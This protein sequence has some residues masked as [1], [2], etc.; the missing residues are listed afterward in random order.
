MCIG[1]SP[2]NN[3]VRMAGYSAVIQS[4]KVLLKEGES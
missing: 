1:K 2:G 4:A 3:I